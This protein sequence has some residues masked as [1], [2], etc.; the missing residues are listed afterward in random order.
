MNP[1]RA[2]FLDCSRTAR[3]LAATP[4]VARQWDEP[5]ALELFSLRGLVGHLMRAT[6]TVEVYLAGDSPP[7]P[8]ISAAA[9]YDAVL[10]TSD[11]TAPTHVDVRAKGE[12]KAA[13]G[14]DAL[15]AE[16]DGIL[17]RLQVRLEEEGAER[18]VRVFGG[19]AMTLDD[20]LVTRIIETVVHADD[21][22]VSVGIATPVFPR[23]AMDAAIATLVDL[24]RLRHG[25]VAVLRAMTRRERDALGA[26]RV[27]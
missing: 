14:R 25:D 12:D 19:V 9:Y 20:Y 22:A 17:E 23:P 1:L 18:R 2:A 6:A 16:W 10:D 11:I 21:V 7:D 27:L 8:G 3:E 4:D 13:A 5:S 26:L 15:L 24:G